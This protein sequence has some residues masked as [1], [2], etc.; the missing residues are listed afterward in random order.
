M[1]NR[2]EPGW[3]QE[4][5]RL[6]R[7][8]GSHRSRVRGNAGRFWQ[9]RRLGSC[10]RW[11]Q[12]NAAV[13][14]GERVFFT[15]FTNPVDGKQLA[16]RRSPCRR[17]IRRRCLPAGR[18]APVEV[19]WRSIPAP[20]AGAAKGALRAKLRAKR[21]ARTPIC[22]RPRCSG[23]LR[24]RLEGV[25]HERGRIAAR[26]LGCESEPVHGHDWLPQL[27]ERV[28]GWRRSCDSLVRASIPVSGKPRACRG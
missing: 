21:C 11:Q 1:P 8:T 25:L 13:D 28:H 3:G 26:S 23:R 14:N 15:D 22:I 10:R 20:T 5:R 6:S 7:R 18:N 2:F 4:Q 9:R 12:F 17:R 19:S 24:R 27:S 16:G